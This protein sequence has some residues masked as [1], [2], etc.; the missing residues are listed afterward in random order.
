MRGVLTGSSMIFGDSRAR[1]PRNVRKVPPRKVLRLIGFMLLLRDR[2]HPPDRPLSLGHSLRPFVD[3]TRFAVTIYLF[4]CI[5]CCS[6]K[7]LGHPQ[8]RSKASRG[9]SRIPP[10]DCCGRTHWLDVDNEFLVSRCT[11]C[12]L[13][14]DVRIPGRGNEVPTGD[15]GLCTGHLHGHPDQAARLF[16]DGRCRSRFANVWTYRTPAIYAE[17]GR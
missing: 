17:C 13:R 3:F 8:G 1:Q 10:D 9:S 5:E 2:L 6:W 4:F 15:A 7:R 14:G 12:V 11:A 16:G